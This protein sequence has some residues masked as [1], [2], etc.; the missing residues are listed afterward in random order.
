MFHFLNYRLHI[1]PLGLVFLLIFCYWFY[2]NRCNLRIQT[3]PELEK[4]L[5]LLQERL[6]EFRQTKPT[7]FCAVA[8]GCLGALAVVGHLVSGSMVVLTGLIL[9]AII[10]TKYNFKIIK[11]EPKGNILK[12]IINIRIK[13]N[14]FFFL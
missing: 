12:K 5:Q 2:K 8:S 4:H 9:A 3:P 7:M 14:L 10:S 1:R 11:I 13:T 6:I